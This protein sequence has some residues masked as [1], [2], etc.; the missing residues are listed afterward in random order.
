[1][2]ALNYPARAENSELRLSRGRLE[3]RNVVKV[4][5]AE[6]KRAVSAQLACVVVAVSRW[7]RLRCRRG[8]SLVSIV[9]AEEQLGGRVARP[10]PGA[11]RGRRRSP[12]AEEQLGAALL[13]AR[14]T[15][16]AG[17][18][19]RRA[20]GAAR[21]R[22]ARREPRSSLQASSRAASRGAARGRVVAR[23]SLPP[24]G[25]RFSCRAK[26]GQLQTVVS[27]VAP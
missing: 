21:R 17:V 8:V 5:C 3:V 14:G 13:V 9:G 20:P 16:L 15:Q 1:M 18:F 11:A 7:S 23:A 10:A 19:A 12:R 26:R 6:Y 4:L 22:G 25:F 24:N 27:Q 2:G